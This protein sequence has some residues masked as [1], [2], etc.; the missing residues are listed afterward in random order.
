MLTRRCWANGLGVLAIVGL[1]AG[2]LVFE[3]VLKAQSLQHVYVA[4][5]CHAHLGWRFS[6]RLST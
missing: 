1:M 2:A 3:H 4:A 6:Q 5:G